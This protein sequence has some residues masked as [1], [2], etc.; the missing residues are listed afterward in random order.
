MTGQDQPSADK[1]ESA[2]EHPFV[3]AFL[4]HLIRERRL[5]A[6]TAQG[7]GHDARVLLELAQEAALQD[8]QVHQIRRF[9]AQLH[10]RGLGGKSLARMLSAW[11]EFFNYLV[12]DHGFAYNPCI[13]S[14]AP[15]T[16]KYMPKALT[17]DPAVRPLTSPGDDP[18]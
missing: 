3:H 7:Y 2:V 11:C 15:R 12:R 10:A 18:L 8:L 17:P 6:H 14:R 9:I 4:S 1:R 16:S 13:R 5:S